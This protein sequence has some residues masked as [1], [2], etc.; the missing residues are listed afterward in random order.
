MDLAT[1]YPG[2]SSPLFRINAYALNVIKRGSLMSYYYICFFWVLRVVSFIMIVGYSLIGFFVIRDIVFGEGVY[3]LS[4]AVAL[5]FA[6]IFAIAMWKVGSIGLR[7]AR[8]RR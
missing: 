5:L 1:L 8:A 4:A 3:G 6:I 7:R 2:R